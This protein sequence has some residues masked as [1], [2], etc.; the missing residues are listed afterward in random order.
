MPFDVHILGY[1]QPLK[2]ESREEMHAE[3]RKIWPLAVWHG[4]VGAYH[5][6]SYL[7]ADDIIAEAW[8]VNKSPMWRLRIREEK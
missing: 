7:G 4:S 1:S 3:V 2:C 5:W 8:M 6:E